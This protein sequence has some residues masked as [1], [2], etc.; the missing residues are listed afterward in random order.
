MLTKAF[1]VTS[2]YARPITIDLISNRTLI[3][4]TLILL[5]PTAQ[6]YQGLQQLNILNLS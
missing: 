6:I 4:I 5:I 1:H 3:T 2:L